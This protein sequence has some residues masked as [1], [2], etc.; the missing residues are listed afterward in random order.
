M[1]LDDLQW[2]GAHS[3]R[4]VARLMNEPGLGGLILVGVFRDDGTG[5]CQAMSS[6]LATRQPHNAPPTHIA[7]TNLGA[8]HSAELLAR[9]LRLAPQRAQELAQAIGVLTDGNPFDTI[10]LVNA[11]RSEGVLS[12]GEAGWQWDALAIRHFVGRGDVADLLAARL[13][14]LAPASRDLLSVMGCL[15]HFVPYALLAAASGCGGAEVREHLR[16]PLEDGLLVAGPDGG[17][18]GIGFRHDRVQQA[19]HAATGEEE[20][21]LRQLAMARRLAAQPHFEA[22]AARQYLAVLGQGLALH[23]AAEMRRAAGLLQGAARELSRIAS[24]E[25]AERYLDAANALLASMADDDADSDLRLQIDYQRHEALYC[26]GRH[27]EAD[28]VFEALRARVVEPVDLVDAASLQIRSLE[29]RGNMRESSALGLDMLAKLGLHAPPAYAVP[30]A[31][32]RLTAVA[33]WI[34][35]DAHTDYASR[36]QVRDR[37]VLAIAKLLVKLT[38]SAYSLVDMDMATWLLLE[39]QR[40]WADHGPCPDMVANFGG[41]YGVY[42]RR[43]QDFRAGYAMCRHAIAVGQALGWEP[44]TAAARFV[45]GGFCCHWFEPLENALHQLELAFEGARGAGD[46]IIASQVHPLMMFCLM[47]LA[48]TL[49]VTQAETENGLALCRQTGNA[50]AAAMHTGSQRLVLALRG[51][52]LAPAS[53]DDAQ[54]SEQDYMARMGHLPYV[55]KFIYQHAFNALILG[56][57]ATLAKFADTPLQPTAIGNYTVFHMHLFVALARAWQLQGKSAANEAQA[58]GQ[59][60]SSLQWLGARA[61]E[62]PYNFLHLLR[63]VQAEQS[64]ALGDFAAAALRFDEALGE[65]GLRPRAWHRALITER[66]GLFH[67][68]RG[69]NHA[70]RGLLMD[71]R[72]Q[73]SEWGAEAKVSEMQREHAFFAAPPRGGE[74][75]PRS[76]RGTGK[77][78]G[79]ISADTLDLLGVLRASQLLSSETSMHRLAARVSDV[80]AALSGATRVLVFSRQDGQWSLLTPYA[81]QASVPLAEASEMGLLPVSVFSYVERI[82]ELLRV[83]DAAMDD[84]FARDPYFAGTGHCSLLAVPIAGQGG[85]SAMLMLENRQGRGAFNAQRLDAV[86][87]IAGQLVVSLANAQLYESLEDRVQART[88]ELTEAQARLVATARRAGMAEIANNVLH[89]VGNVLNSVNVSASLARRT[90]N[91]SRLEGLARAVAIINEHAADLGGFIRSDPRGG[92]LVP[93]LNELVLALQSDRDCA[94]QELER[95]ISSVDHISYVVATQQSH[96]GPSSVLEP[97]KPQDLVEEALRIS[98]EAIARHGVSVMRRYADIPTAELDRQR[99]LQI[100]VNLICNAAQA[101]E[102]VPPGSRRLSVDTLLKRGDAGDRLQIVVQDQGEG[103]AAQDMTRIFSHGFTTR[104]DGHGFGLHSSALAA[105]EM[106]GW[107]SADSEGPGKGARFTLEL[108]FGLRDPS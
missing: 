72:D 8:M 21:A 84:R 6:L 69:L 50:V 35:L 26:L 1:V 29:A 37:R 77:S 86:K 56:D 88:R 89:N 67:L 106:G 15:G 34:A 81:T 19:V 53:F 93:Y 57:G 63:L 79:N 38:R 12:L 43:R 85:L 68:A 36:P 97:A 24:Y 18:D 101:M 20:R 4:G 60:G 47:D 52:T 65:A 90:L 48:P 7:L 80:L 100:L 41:F 55:Y 17:P 75:A 99:L 2:A 78:S 66:A 54:F 59:L 91:G 14:R 58:A 42:V 95:L 82:G 105:L 31:D 73:Y 5:P 87:L 70:G 40:L 32:A 83:D 103:I 49:D 3:L 45:F 74:R 96:A 108:P 64:W 16:V 28:A 39:S 22:Q 30:D 10:E 46:P 104:R 76:S 23:D 107:L 62:Q 71:A 13:A 61:L 102:N 51:L 44:Q 94:D 98:A 27:A 11:L 33:E 25:F 9:L 92:A